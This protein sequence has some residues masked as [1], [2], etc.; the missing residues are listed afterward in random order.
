MLYQVL[1]TATGEDILGDAVD[2]DSLT[3][4]IPE[5]LIQCGGAIT[6]RMHEEDSDCFVETKQGR[7]LFYDIKDERD[8]DGCYS[9]NVFCDVKHEMLF[10]SFRLKPEAV[11]CFHEPSM[12]SFIMEY[13]KKNY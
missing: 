3:T 6:I 4:I 1:S 9:I 12:G 13:I 7:I 5:L 2:I 8:V 10:D 11:G